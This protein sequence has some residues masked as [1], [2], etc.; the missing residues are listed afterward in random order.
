MAGRAVGEISNLNRRTIRSIPNP[1]D[2]GTVVSIYPKNITEIKHTI[3]PGRF[4]IPA[5]SYANPSFLVVGPSSWWRDVGPHEPL[6][7][8]PTSAVQIA[9][10]IVIDYYNG[11]L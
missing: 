10:S 4:H 7:E 1:M 8:I 11:L 6:L 9:N 5:G 3:Q 2:K